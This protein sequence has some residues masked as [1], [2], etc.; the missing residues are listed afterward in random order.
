MAR[1]AVVGVGAIGG[2]IAALLEMAGGHEITLCTRRPLEQL[3][4]TMPSGLVRVKVTQPDDSR[5]R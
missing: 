1:I 4:V 5:N 3:T 2:A